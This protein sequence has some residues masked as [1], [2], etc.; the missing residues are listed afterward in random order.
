MCIWC[1]QG[2]DLVPHTEKSTN[3]G[4]S[5][6]AIHVQ[7]LE[8]IPKCSRSDA[9]W[10]KYE[11]QCNAASQY[12]EAE[13]NVWLTSIGAEEA[14]EISNVFWLFKQKLSIKLEVGEI[15]SELLKMLM[16]IHS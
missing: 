1:E 7:G 11:N 9:S 14:P 5:N 6:P 10:S 8:V 12:S 15:Y 2:L 4:K 16:K 3:T 13:Q